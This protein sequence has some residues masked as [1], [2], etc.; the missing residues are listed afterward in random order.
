M[1]TCDVELRHPRRVAL[2]MVI[3]EALSKAECAD[4][5]C[6]KEDIEALTEVVVD[7]RERMKEPYAYAVVDALKQQ[8]GTESMEVT[9]VPAALENATLENFF[10]FPW[11]HLTSNGRILATGDL[12]V[13]DKDLSELKN[14]LFPKLRGM[15]SLWSEDLQDDDLNEHFAGLD[16]SFSDLQAEW[17]GYPLRVSV[18]GDFIKVHMTP[19]NDECDLLENMEIFKLSGATEILVGNRLFRGKNEDLCS[20]SRELTFSYERDE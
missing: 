14:Q 20:S 16:I 1:N 7:A 5:A 6:S 4:G 3:E 8:C 12:E 15:P 9:C 10:A 19:P 11:L 13:K 2:K 18:A 17:S